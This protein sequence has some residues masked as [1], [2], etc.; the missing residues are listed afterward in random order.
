MFIF[1]AI[2]LLLTLESATPVPSRVASQWRERP[3]SY[4]GDHNS[5][6]MAGAPAVGRR[7]GT[8]RTTPSNYV[9]T[10]HALRSTLFVSAFGPS[11][12]LPG[13]YHTNDTFQLRADDTAVRSTR[14][15][16]AFG[17]ISSAPAVSH[18]PLRSGTAQAPSIRLV[19]SA[20]SQHVVLYISA[21]CQ[22]KTKIARR[23][24]L[25]FCAS[26]LRHMHD[27][28]RT[29]ILESTL[30]RTIDGDFAC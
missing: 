5:S 10:T 17:R 29:S 20:L 9:R 13:T 23:P 22:H 16:S 6:E 7:A 11:C 1:V 21:I 28:P 4:N 27:V 18:R 24:V 15:V 25:L 14:L 3:S 19:C 8:P 30:R 12:W 26:G 2:L